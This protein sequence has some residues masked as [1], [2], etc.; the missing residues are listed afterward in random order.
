ME[1]FAYDPKRQR[2]GTAPEGRAMSERPQA[3]LVS[4][5][6]RGASA[7]M[8]TARS[9][10]SARDTTSSS[11]A[12]AEREGDAGSIRSMGDATA[13]RMC[14]DQV[15]VD[16]RSALKE[17]VENALDAGATKIDVKLRE[18][19]AETLEVWDNGGG[20]AQSDLPGVARRHHTS[21]LGG[22]DDLGKLTSF[23]FRGEALSS[24]AALSTLSVATRTQADAAGTCLTFG[25]DG[26]VASRATV[27]REVGTTV[28]VTRLFEPFAV[29][30]RELVRPTPPPRRQP[31][32]RFVIDQTGVLLLATPLPP[33]I[34]AR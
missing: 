9:G 3:G 13:L 19:G 11:E 10:G 27:P 29:R 1:A 32:R 12:A 4:A 8:G 14:S 31:P 15:V 21:K 34:L 23:G 2:V 28:I 25:R 16:L 18:H 5:T 30:R 20:I 17:L 26:S 24:L 22:Y 7:S 6:L 33:P